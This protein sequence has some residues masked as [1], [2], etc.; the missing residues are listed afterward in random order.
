[1]T[2]IKIAKT[3]AVL[4]VAGGGTL[5]SA[6]ETTILDEVQIV[7]TASGFEQDIIDAPASITVITAKDL[8]GKSYRD[9]TDALQDIP[10]ITVEGGAGGKIE[11]TAIY[12]RGMAEKYTLFMVDGKPQGS[13]QAYYNG[14]GSAN[15]IGWLPP[16]SSIERIEVIKGPMSS[17]YGSDALGGVINIITKKVSN[18]WTGSL[19]LDTVI[20]EN[21]KSGDSRQYRYYLSGP[22]IQD[23][24]GLSVYG[25]K[26]HR[27]EDDFSSGFREK[28]KWDNN[29]KLNWK[30]NDANNLELIYGKAEQKNKGTAEKTGSTEMNN[31]RENVSLSH[32]LNW[33]DSNKTTTYYTREDVEIDN[34][35]SDSEYIR[36]TFNTKTIMPIS[37]NNTAT[38]GLDYKQE[39]TK[40]AKNR[41]HGKANA[42]LERWQGAAFLEDEWFITDD[43][44]IT[45]GLRYDKNEHYGSEFI[46]RLYNVYRLS[47]EFTLKGGV[48]KGY[49]APELKQA[50]PSIAEQS[51]G[52]SPRQRLDIGNYDLKP[53]SS[54]NYE[55]A[56]LWNNESGFDAGVTVYHTEFKDK[57]EKERICESPVGGT[58][59]ANDIC[60][61]NGQMWQGI[62]EYT[63]VSSA[64]LQGI[65]SSFGYRNDYAKISLN[66][67]YSDSEQKSGSSKGKP[68]NNLPKHMINLGVDYYINK[69][70]TTW[71]KIKYKGK[72][73]EDSSSQ[74][75]DYTLVDLGINY[76]FTKYTSFYAGIY[77]LFDKQITT[78]DNG[79]TL[80]GR[81]Y[82]IGMKLD[83]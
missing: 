5:L 16:L 1:M 77:N 30:V 22:I 66:H 9:V 37:D 60:E 17:L 47:E 15:E 27:D 20:Q 40:H 67:T 74:R 80:D 18:K 26:Y 54:V 62:N 19:S 75:P 83:F 21:D 71:T 36:D 48:S 6:N 56:L 55:L 39:E 53:E 33:L 58:N 41:F 44:S 4:L 46:P 72:T 34:G 63:N 38:L 70:I 49:V 73:I 78:A 10:G 51:M 57:I 29:A 2:K 52:N 50:D 35:S 59:K 79:K 28:D 45:T 68:L 69:D 14:F 31:K 65:E 43:W 7:S 32:E 11:S 3:L 24:L 23:K 76:K 8:E 64:E 12:I 81:R 25:S 61:Y 13:S 42:N 82:N